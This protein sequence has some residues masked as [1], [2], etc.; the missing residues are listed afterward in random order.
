MGVLSGLALERSPA[1]KGNLVVQQPAP[2]RAGNVFDG[3]VFRSGFS[4]PG[5]FPVDT[6]SWTR[7]GTHSGFP[8]TSF[9]HHKRRLAFRYGTCA[10]GHGVEFAGDRGTQAGIQ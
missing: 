7:G 1:G 8:P 2:C 6:L 10:D 9:R 4:A 5:S 3:K